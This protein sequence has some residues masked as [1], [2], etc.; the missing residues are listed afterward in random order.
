MDPDHRSRNDDFIPYPTDRAV[1]TIDDPKD[2]W[3][4]LEALPREGFSQEQ[5]DVLH[6]EGGLEHHDPA[7]SEHALLARVQRTLIPTAGPAEE[8]KHLSRHIEDVRAG[9]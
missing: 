1:G 2:A 3:A 4:A 8:Y 5:L 6:G 9:R 7:V